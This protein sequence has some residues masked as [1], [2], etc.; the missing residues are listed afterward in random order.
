MKHIMTAAALS[1]ALGAG[2]TL[3]QNAPGQAERP[4]APGAQAPLSQAQ[5]TRM[6]ER[7]AADVMA[8]Q[9]VGYLAADKNLQAS[10]AMLGDQVALAAAE[11]NQRLDRVVRDNNITLPRR[12]DPQAMARFEQMK[13]MNQQRFAQNFLAFINDTYPRIISGIEGLARTSAQ[14]PAIAQL[15]Q[16]SLPKLR[17]QLRSAQQLAQGSP[18]GEQAAES[19]ENRGPIQRKDDPAVIPDQPNQPGPR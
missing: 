19:P 6:L 15:T 17:D 10:Y 3:A 9:Q 4:A 16:D 13:E 11:V 5:E 2:P 8:A 14:S 18:T 12:M 7:L 1:L